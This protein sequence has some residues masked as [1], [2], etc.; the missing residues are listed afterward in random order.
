MD[1]QEFSLLTDLYELTMAQ[2]YFQHGMSEPS[3]FSLHI[4]SYPPNRAYFIV[5]GLSDVIA[6]LEHL[7]F[8]QE[9][10]AYLESTGIFDRN[11]LQ[12]LRNLRFTGEVWAIPEGR[13]AFADEPILEVTAPV[14]EAQIVETFIINQIH[15]QSL[16]ATKASRCVWAARDRSVV[17]FGLR[18]THGIDAGLKVARASYIAGCQSTSNVL[19]G[20]LYGI[21]ITGTMAHSFVT[22]FDDELDAFRAYGDSFP[23]RAVLLLD[24]YDTIAAAHKAVMVAKEMESR[25]EQLQGVRLDSGDLVTLSREVRQILNEADLHYVN[26]VASGGLDEYQVEEL[27]LKEAPIDVFAIGTRMGVS[28]DSPWADMAYK[29][30]EYGGRPI[31]KL[32]PR[33]VSLP[34]GKQVFRIRDHS[35]NFSHDILA[36]RD[37]EVDGEPLL[38]RVMVKGQLIKPSPSLG[39]IRQRFSEEFAHLD[40]RYKVLRNPPKYPV[41]LSPKLKELTHS[42]EQQISSKATSSTSQAV[43]HSG[44]DL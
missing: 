23:S 42:L 15:L 20:K 31:M 36:L 18:R 25:G 34:G 37:E 40:E 35:D 4:R 27:L 13:V 7:S 11:F 10:L 26:I 38:E 22:S 30:V 14:M 9:S 32:S 2:S 39:E 19:A 24:T 3:T 29:Q 8:S 6:Y 12:S 28:D 33:K 41:E 43:Q 5:A 21:P 44:A 17:D 1:L 16:M